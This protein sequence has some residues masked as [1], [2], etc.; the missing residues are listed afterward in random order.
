MPFVVAVFL[1]LGVFTGEPTGPGQKP[2]SV[3]IEYVQDGNK[4][5]LKLE[6]QHLTLM[7]PERSALGQVELG[8]MK[9]EVVR[10]TYGR[11]TPQPVLG[12]SGYSLRF[13]GIYPV[14][15]PYSTGV[16]PGSMKC[17]TFS[18]KARLTGHVIHAEGVS[19]QEA[20]NP[21]PARPRPVTG[22]RLLR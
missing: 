14:W 15:G 19:S 12:T 9:A 17:L 16:S 20:H 5:T 7:M 8:L 21:Y 4:F 11:G 18:R 13:T 10:L 2:G 6:E 3:I 22:V 1:A